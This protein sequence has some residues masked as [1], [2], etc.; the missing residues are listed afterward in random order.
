MKQ[1]LITGSNRGIGLALVEA[2]ARAGDHVHAV[3]RQRSARLEALA[4]ETMTSIVADVDVRDTKSLIA[5]A[6]LCGDPIDVLICNAGMLVSDS[7]PSLLDGSDNDALLRQFEVNALGALRTVTSFLRCMRPGGKIGLV[8]SLMGS[9]SDNASG[10]Y[11]GYRMSKAALNAAGVSLA[12]DLRA[13]GI[14]VAVLHPGYV[15]TDMTEGRGSLSPQE[16][17]RGLMA[18]LETLTLDD[19]GGFWHTDGRALHW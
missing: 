14:A 3:C 7:L 19:S 18:R 6:A 9:M 17:A 15:D 10:G 12:C 5:A 11:Y 4:K 16:S 13:A 1:I 2:Y 8:S